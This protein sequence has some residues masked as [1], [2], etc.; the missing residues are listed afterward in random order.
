MFSSSLS[1]GWR[2]ILT[3][4]FELEKDVFVINASEKQRAQSITNLKATSLRKKHLT[5]IMLWCRCLFDNR[6][7][8]SGR[9][10]TPFLQIY[11]T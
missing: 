5:K 3:K 4:G 2:D 8:V 1:S 10:K 6:A 9:Y 7:L 11:K